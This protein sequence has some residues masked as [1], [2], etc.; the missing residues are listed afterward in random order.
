MGSQSAQPGKGINPERPSGRP[1][2]VQAGTPLG[3]VG[4]DAPEEEDLYKCVHCGLCLQ[5]CPTYIQLGDETEAPRGRIALMKGVYQG[6]IGLTEGVANHLELCLQCRACEAACPAGVPYGRMMEAARTQLASQRPKSLTRRLGLFVGLRLLAHRVELLRVAAWGLKVYQRSGVQGMVRGLGVLRFIG[7]LDRMERQ[8]PRL[9]RFY[10]RPTEPVP[11]KSTTK[12]RVGLLDGC[13]MPFV[14]GRVNEATTNVLTRNGCDVVVPAQ[15]CCGALS[16]HLGERESG[17][18]L[19]RR[20][21]D[22][23]LNEDVEA[24]VVNSAGCGST[25][26]EYGDLLK[27]DPVYAEKAERFAGMVKDINEF[28][29][30]LPI[31]AP[32]NELQ[33]RVTYQDS[34]HLAHAQGIVD[35]PRQLLGAIPGLKLVEMDRSDMCCGAAGV[36]NVTHRTMSERL[37]EDKMTRVSSTGAEIIATANPGC[38]LQLES[39]ARERGLDVRVVHVVELLDEAYSAED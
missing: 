1:P 35:A 38:M 21:I 9:G 26:K 18:A 39:G 7:A 32:A 13:V 30:G 23:F 11:S 36:Y 10:R 24:I 4:A 16:T 31:E 29:A 22:A 2:L 6:R 17:R 5:V 12:I 37:L 27:D 33:A 25:M 20:N 19:A 15:G 14:Y 8:L 3:F 28:L 34:C